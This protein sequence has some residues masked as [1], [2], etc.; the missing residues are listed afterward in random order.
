MIGPLCL[1]MKAGCLAKVQM[2]SIMYLWKI[3]CIMPLA[4]GMSRIVYINLPTIVEEH[5]SALNFKTVPSWDVCSW[6]W[7]QNSC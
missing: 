7:V 6:T 2:I 5:L 3:F 1:M 4:S